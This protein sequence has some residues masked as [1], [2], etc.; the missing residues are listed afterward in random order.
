MKIKI[1][2]KYVYDLFEFTLL[3]KVFNA[4][5]EMLLALVILFDRDIK[6]SIFSFTVREIRK[7]PHDIISPYIQHLL[8]NISHATEIF[9]AVYLLAQ[10]LIKILLIFGLLKKKLW[11]YP[12]AMYTFL[13]FIA[14][15]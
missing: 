5:W 11:V 4:V 14:Y 13:L 15:Q 9:I 7:H 6:D 10:G 3:L 1:T 12:V 2:E 8:P